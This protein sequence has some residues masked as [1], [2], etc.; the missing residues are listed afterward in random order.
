M[1]DKLT[2]NLQAMKL[3]AAS[4]GKAADDLRAGVETTKKLEITASE[5]GTFADALSKYQPAPGYFRDRLN[6]GV[7]VFEDIGK[8]LKFAADTYEA[9][10]LASKGKLRKLEGEI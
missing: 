6:E 9:E 4:W 1:A 3:A 2:L 10:D 8:V 5:A 7:T